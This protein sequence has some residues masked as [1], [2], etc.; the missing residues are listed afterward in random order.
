M[1]IKEIL[2][3]EEG[4]WHMMV[5]RVE[6]HNIKSNHLYY[7]MLDEFCFMSKNLYN[8]A[9]YQIRQSFIKEDGRFIGYY[10]MDKLLKTDYMDFDYRNMP[11][12]DSAQQCLRLLE[13]NWKSFFASIK[14][15]SKDK[16]RYTG[17]P[18]LPK[19]LDK[20]G[21]NL[22]ILTKSNCKV[23]DG[24]IRFPKTFKGFTL[25]TKVNNLQQVRVL[26][27]NNYIT[28]EVIYR[29]E[30]P[31]EIIDNNRYLGI[32]IGLDNLGTITNNFGNKPFIINGKHI[33]SIN[34]YYNKK[35]SKQRKIA[36]RMNDSNWTKEMNKLTIKRNNMIDDKLHKA[37]K[38]IID[39]AL[40]CEANTIVIGN[41]K[42][43]KR[44]STMSKKV[45]QKFIGIPHQRLIQMIQYKAE[46]V[47]INVVLTE[48]S[49]TSGT[50]FLDNE[51][52]NKQNYNKSRRVHRG[53]FVSSDG[54][55]I[56]ADVN[57][58]LQIIKKVFPNAFSNGIEDVGLHPVRVT[59]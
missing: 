41:N 7:H 16:D 47:G 10:E 5:T 53:L 20:S 11:S 18:K 40:S 32:D 23:K 43:W 56:N 54:K 36:K 25:K 33:K 22:L 35:L 14:D 37:S 45:N 44:D 52:P 38:S 39:Y 13:K 48:E 59:I 50:S 1:K 42:D 9:N 4:G 55:K 2:K 31:N 21:R 27:R 46:N 28:I 34:Q 57:G 24:V 49:Y 8:F 19:Y 30:V 58:S 12:A 15:W 17:K 3:Q 26:P 51:M 29:V 6:K